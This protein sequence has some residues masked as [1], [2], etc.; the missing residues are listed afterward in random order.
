MTQHIRLPRHRGR[1]ATAAAAAA[2]LAAAAVVLDGPSATASGQ[3]G[4][5]SAAA[6][7]AAA[8]L[9]TPAASLP[10]DAD[11]YPERIIQLAPSGSQS[12]TLPDGARGTLTASGHSTASLPFLE[13]YVT[14]TGSSSTVSWTGSR[15][16]TADRVTLT[17]EWDVEYVGMKYVAFGL[18]TG[19]Q[20][21]SGPGSDAVIWSTT[22]AGTAT[23]SHSWGA[24]GFEPP[25]NYGQ[26]YRVQHKV[27]GTFSFGSAVFSVSGSD[28]QYS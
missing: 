8:T 27:T 26:V 24:V 28:T 21:V 11:G 25:D 5:V 4:T 19:A 10:L 18:P 6:A 22:T 9:P 23:A 13:Y 16:L 12:V 14:F 17:D 7:R 3:H 2:L 15:P 20:E 1:V